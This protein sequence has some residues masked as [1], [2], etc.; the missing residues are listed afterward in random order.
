MHPQH[1]MMAVATFVFV[2]FYYVAH[3]YLC[4]LIEVLK[5]GPD[6]GRHP[7]TSNPMGLTRESS[8]AGLWSLLS[9][10]SRC[11]LSMSRL[12][13]MRIGCGRALPSETVTMPVRT[14]NR[15][16]SVLSENTAAFC[17]RKRVSVQDSKPPLNFSQE[18]DL[19]IQF[20]IKSF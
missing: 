8:G 14:C 12:R 18:N 3:L 4:A 17:C 9:T 15:T 2:A 13:C 6:R 19:S 5:N 10:S 7:T 1:R 11:R 20:L 16:S